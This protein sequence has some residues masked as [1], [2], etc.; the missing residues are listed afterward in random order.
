M[1]RAHVSTFLF[2]DI[3]G[4]TRR[5]EADPDAMRSALAAHDAALKD[6]ITDYD[7]TLFKH[8]GDGICA[9]FSS[10]T[11][12]VDAAITGQ[13]T[14]QL[15]VRM[16]IATG[17]AQPR[18]GDYFGP[19]LN[20]AARIMAAG[21]GGQILL[22]GQT[23]GL[24]T[25]TALKDH[26]TRRLRDIATPVHIHQ[27]VADGLR[28]DFPALRT[29]DRAPGNLRSVPTSFVGRHAESAALADA[30]DHHRLV[31]LTGPGGVG[32]TRLALEVA[33]RTRHHYPDGVFVV[34]LAAVGDP[35][36]IPAAVTA[37]VG[38]T[39]QPGQSLTES[40][41][42][43]LEERHRL[44]VFDNCEH[45]VDAAAAM[46]EAIL[47]AA[48]TAT[49]LATS[50][51][52]LRVADERLWPVPPLEPASDAV[53]LFLARAAGVSEPS[54][55]DATAVAEICRRLDGIPLAIE[56]AASRLQSM[57]VAELRDRLDDRF[58]LLVGSRRGLERHQ[59]LRHAVQWSYDLL[60]DAEKSLLKACSVFS[61]GFDIAAAVAVS[62]HADEYTALDLLD[63]LVRKSLVVADRTGSSTRF[64]ML[65]T[66]RQFA[67]EQL[68]AAGL[69]DT[70]RSA[71]AAHFAS[72]E[73]EL[74][75]LWHSPRQREAYEWFDTEL[76]NLRSGFRWAADRG[77][78]DAAT[79]IVVISGFLALWG[80]QSYETVAWAE[81]MLAPAEAADHTQLARLY[82]IAAQCYSTGRATEAVRYADTCQHLIDTGQCDPLPFDAEVWMGGGYLGLGAP[83]RWVELCRRVIERPGD[84]IVGRSALVLA[85][86][87]LGATEDL[88]S[89]A[90]GLDT[91]AE[92]T[93]NPNDA[94]FAL[95]VYGIARR[96]VDPEDAYHVLTRALDIARDSGNRFAELHIAA[97]LS[98]LSA[99]HRSAR[100]AFGFLDLVIR[101]YRDSGSFIPMTSPLV[102]MAELFSRLGYH[103]CAARLCGFS[104]NPWTLGVNPQLQV[105]VERLTGALG[106]E[107]FEALAAA[108]RATSPGAM[109]AYALEQLDLARAELE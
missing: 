108:G 42:T 81:E 1:E 35:E 82:S 7:G 10:P 83:H 11:A 74:T 76:A 15:P 14:L 84:H 49:I 53:A 22:D 20:R 34:E 45:V 67:E 2:T 8:T 103:E 19:V 47:A 59:T 62:G 26:G 27:I 30:L 104:T 39:Q 60:D 41:A 57:T 4:S 38:V 87:S 73:P 72:L 51:E 46:V 16:G 12:A 61:G 88:V 89:A 77:E 56:L 21:H 55:D 99:A 79:G 50:R 25:G 91:A 85:L 3:E 36:A 6:A 106:A 23:A 109:A 31:T 96:S 94:A 54:D 101:Q 52:G 100:E 37:A 75:A 70:T 68:V 95:L 71:H 78:I 24:L 48:P 90:A 69:A 93:D 65:E 98:R 40:I 13:R 44:L 97:S 32:K 18:D 107:R 92:R 9:V 5:W 28:T 33:S 63:A 43:A 102:I 66:I 58:R 86:N 29:A 64:S 17:E 105:A 80:R